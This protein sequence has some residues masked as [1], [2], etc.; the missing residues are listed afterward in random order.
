MSPA[1]KGFLRKPFS[2]NHLADISA[3]DD[4]QPGRTWNDR[5]LFPDRERFSIGPCKA[6]GTLIRRIRRNRVGMKN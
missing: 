2:F 1:A 5:G 3:V 4:V 6:D